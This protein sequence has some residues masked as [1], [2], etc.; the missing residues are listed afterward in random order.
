[1]GT[2][3]NVGLPNQPGGSAAQSGGGNRWIT[4]PKHMALFVPLQTRLSLKTAQLAEIDAST[5]GF[6]TALALR[7]AS[8]SISVAATYATV[9]NLTGAGFLFNAVSP[10]HSASFIP[11]FRI[12]VDG[13]VYV[14]APS[15]AQTAGNRMVMGPI[16]PGLPSISAGA[17]APINADLV[18]INGSNDPGFTLGLTGGIAV[19]SNISYF[20]IPTPEIILS[21]GMQ[22]LRF[23]KSLKVEMMCDL[24]SGTAVDKQCG[25]TFR[26][27]L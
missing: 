5:A 11:T 23:E 7:G 19:G 22:C 27:D 13:T 17:S 10:G 26:M 3:F 12:T 24:L 18:G 16:T 6:F 4:N 14:I 9:C 21:Y 25:V 1:M 20:G 15:A 2:V 8:T